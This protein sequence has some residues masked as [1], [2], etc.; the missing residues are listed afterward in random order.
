MAPREQIPHWGS[1]T[2]TY[3]D[4]LSPLEKLKGKGKGTRPPWAVPGTS[5]APQTH[6]LLTISV[7]MLM[8]S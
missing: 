7:T 8:N 3:P 6:R 5:V 2:G 1:Q 4:P